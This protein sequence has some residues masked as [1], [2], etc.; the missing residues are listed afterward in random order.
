MVPG[1]GVEPARPEG[2]GILSP[3]RMPF[4]H[5][6]ADRVS[7]SYDIPSRKVRLRASILWQSNPNALL[8]EFQIHRKAGRPAFIIQPDLFA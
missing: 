1:A 4:R 6:G 5:P 8:L 3:P 7:L 2:Q